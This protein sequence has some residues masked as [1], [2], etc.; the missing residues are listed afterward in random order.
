MSWEG[1][2]KRETASVDMD[3]E[4]RSNVGKENCKCVK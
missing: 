4:E 3:A 2:G 1:V